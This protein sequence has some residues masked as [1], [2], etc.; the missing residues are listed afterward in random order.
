MRLSFEISCGSPQ[1]TGKH[2][3][4]YSEAYS[5]T[6]P[7][8]IAMPVSVRVRAEPTDDSLAYHKGDLSNASSVMV[9]T[10]RYALDVDT[11]MS[12]LLHRS[13]A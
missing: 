13:V 10:G 9:M 4:T 7:A 6:D 8:S 2:A 3:L 12:S 1:A 11:E 5:R